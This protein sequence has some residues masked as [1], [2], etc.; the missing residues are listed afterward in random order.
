MRDILI[1]VKS[2][3]F[4]Q[5]E[6]SRDSTIKDEPIWKYI[7]SSLIVEARGFGAAEIPAFNW[8]KYIFNVEIR[9]I[10]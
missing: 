1:P 3:K 7:G 6:S 9:K 4:G 10:L 2:W 8:K 5:R